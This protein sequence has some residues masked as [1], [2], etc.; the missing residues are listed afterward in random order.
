MLA[1][2]WE[3]TDDETKDL[4]T[5]T[6][7]LIE[8]LQSVW[9]KAH[10]TLREA[11][12]KQKRGYDTR[13][14]LRSLK[15][16]DKALVLLP[17]SENKL[18]A[19]W[20]GPYEVLEQINPTTY[21]LALCQHQRATLPIGS[22]WCPWDERAVKG[23][24]PERQEEIVGSGN[25]QEAAA[26]QTRRNKKTKEE[27]SLRSSGVPGERTRLEPRALTVPTRDEDSRPM[28]ACA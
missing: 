26:E 18:L 21:K 14:V 9:E 1:E 8:N 11:Q 3:E 23:E 19:R 13:S 16:V 2:Q 24:V 15:I 27:R 10:T 7:E 25:L 6:K 17:S 12:E 28:E 4:L 22:T 5:Y 20:Q